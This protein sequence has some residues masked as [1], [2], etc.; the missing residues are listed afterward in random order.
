M[1]NILTNVAVLLQ[2]CV[3]GRSV[4][5][6]SRDLSL[7][8][9]ISVV[10]PCISL[11]YV[12]ET[13]RTEERYFARALQSPISIGPFHTFS[14]HNPVCYLTKLDSE[15]YLEDVGT[16]VYLPKSFERVVYK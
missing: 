11:R 1:L 8:A 3:V 14:S 15:V 9:N 16:R 6:V 4:L 7:P 2:S 12:A 10:K 5:L 13:I